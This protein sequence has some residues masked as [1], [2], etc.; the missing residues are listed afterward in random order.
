MPSGEAAWA[1]QDKKP[2]A[3]IISAAAAPR[4]RPVIAQ[5]ETL[6]LAFNKGQALKGRSNRCGMLGRPFRAWLAWE[7]IPRV[8]PWAMIGGPFRARG[9]RMADLVGPDNSLSG[10]GSAPAR[11]HRKRRATLRPSLPVAPLR[12]ATRTTSCPGQ[13]TALPCGLAHE[14]SEAAEA[15]AF[16]SATWERE[17]QRIGP[18]GRRSCLPARPISLISPI[19]P[20]RWLRT[21]PATSPRRGRR[22]LC[23]SWP[24]RR[25]RSSGRGPCGRRARLCHR[26]A[27]CSG[28]RGARC[29]CARRS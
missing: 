9:E 6:G 5:G 27:R 28:R 25:R 14:G 23:G 29:N 18:M 15:S 8:S 3:P 7:F 24:G 19:S 22:C 20:I 13:P 1:G 4:G 16:P 17:R 21:R 12:C 11:T 10:C 2:T 26:V